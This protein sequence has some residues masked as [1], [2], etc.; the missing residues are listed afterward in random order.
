MMDVMKRNADGRF[1]LGGAGNPSGANGHCKG[2]QRFGDRAIKL[3]DKYTTAQILEFGRNE[4]KLREELS[5]WDA[6][7]IK[8]MAASISGENQ[9]AETREL[10]DRI[11]GKPVQ[12]VDVT[13]K[14]E[15]QS[16]ILSQDD[17]MLDCAKRIAFI[18]S[19]GVKI[20][21]ERAATIDQA[22]H[23]ISSRSNE[24]PP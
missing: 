13:Q 19:R 4:R 12:A 7:C 5:F 11:E 22:S 16:S 23:A 8:R 2:W 24:G 21:N 3:G 20:K 14:I 18:L 6:Q 15:P 1:S 17:R 10:I 9:L